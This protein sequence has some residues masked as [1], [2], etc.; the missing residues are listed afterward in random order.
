MAGL[1]PAMIVSGFSPILALKNKINSASVGGISLRRSLVVL[2]FAI[3]QVLI[4]GTLIA[5]SQMN[6]YKTQISDLIKK[7]F[8]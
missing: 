1:Y 3:S 6:L 7:G 8:L 4:V 2:Q 5:V